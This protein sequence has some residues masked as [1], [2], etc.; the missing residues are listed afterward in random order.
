MG[1]TTGHSVRT[2]SMSFLYTFSYMLACTYTPLVFPLIFH[3]IQDEI[4]EASRPL[5]TRL[6]QLWLVLA[7]TMII[8]LVACIFILIAGAS[9]GGS[10]VGSSIGW[11]CL[12]CINLSVLMGVHADTSC[13]LLPCHSYCGIGT[14]YMCVCMRVMN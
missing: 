3:S 2:V 1:V 6:Y 5:I 12:Q 4:P 10:D 13:S 7:G 11:V 14:F 9:G 8:N